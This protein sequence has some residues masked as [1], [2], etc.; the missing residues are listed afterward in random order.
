MKNYS[1]EWKKEINLKQF[2]YEDFVTDFSRLKNGIYIEKLDGM[3]GTLI[4]ENGKAVFQTTTG[5]I[6]NEIPCAYE[7]ES[8]FKKRN[9]KE[10]IIPG[11]LVA[12]KNNT[13]LPFNVTQSIVKR[14][15]QEANKNLIYHYPLDVI[16]IDGKSPNFRQSISIITRSFGRT[17]HI[18]LPKVVEGDIESFRK[19]YKSLE[20]EVGFDG[21][22]ARNLGGKNYKIKFTNSADL[23]VIGAGKEGLP[24]WEKGQASYLLTAF[25]DKNGL[26]RTSSKVGTGMT[27]FR[28]DA[29]YR[30]VHENKL[31]KSGG[32]IFVKPILVIEVKY[33]RHRI[34]PTPTYKFVNDKYVTAGK[35]KSITF[36]HPSFERMRTD[37]KANKY[38]TRLEQL[39]DWRY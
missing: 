3:L 1:L 5:A 11:E 25:V 35:N 32:E 2:S 39:P 27:H 28:R 21:V 29:F 12:K 26:F 6:I 13:I 34:T 36:S 17:A 22:V 18:V 23:V 7:Y 31:Y 19:M 4:Y 15:H 8:L 37:K 16:S 9:V 20:D 14:F 10:A 30:F 33:F 38:D 24:A